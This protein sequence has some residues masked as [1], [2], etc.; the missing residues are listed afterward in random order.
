MGSRSLIS[1]LL[2]LLI[3]NGI[4]TACIDPI[5][6]EAEDDSVKLVIFGSFSDQYKDHE[7]S[8]RVTGKFG[9][10]GTVV[11]DALVEVIDEDGNK[12]RFYESGEGKYIL[13]KG[14]MPG[15][16]GKA[17]KLIVTL[18]NNNIYESTWE[19][20][21]EPANI[22][23]TYFEINFR[24]Q[25][26]EYDNVIQQFF[27]DVFI[28][29]PLRTSTGRK[30]YFRWEVDETYSFTDLSCGGLD[31]VTVCY[32]EVPSA[33][34]PLEIYEAFDNQQQNLTKYPVFSRLIVPYVEFNE[35]H[36]FNVSQ[37]SISKS[38]YEYWEKI[39]IV[40]NPTGSIFD[41]IPAGITGNFKS[42]NDN[43]E[44]LGYFEVASVT[45]DRTVSTW[46]DV[47]A[48]IQIPQTCS[49]FVPRF[50]LPDYCCYCF[51]LPNTIP[52]PNYWGER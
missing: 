21:P 44:V 8:I 41:K 20:M 9:S 45:V 50:R 14:E 11:P 32:F 24:N 1:S 12:A 4:F 42:I 19:L 15:I 7:V 35:L 3:L 26:T 23:N 38:T 18:P 22:E 10:V 5:A 13:P 16:P 52:K 30:A 29:T 37:Y 36:Y 6:F 48:K 43:N 2:F 28:D 49:P 40:S 33:F 17:Y 47:N 46:Q 31:V 25:L 27:I 34:Q 51:V 39:N